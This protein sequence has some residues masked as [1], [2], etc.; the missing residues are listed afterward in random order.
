MWGPRQHY[1]VSPRPV[2]GIFQ[3]GKS[4][5][6]PQPFMSLSLSSSSCQS[7]PSS[8]PSVRASSSS[9]LH[10]PAFQLPPAP[11]LLKVFGSHSSMSLLFTGHP[12]HSPPLRPASGPNRCGQGGESCRTKHGPYKEDLGWRGAFL[13]FSY[14]ERLWAVSPFPLEGPFLSLGPRQVLISPLLSLPTE[15]LW[16]L[17]SK[18]P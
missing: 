7:Q 4:P 11:G 15:R 17:P 16:V 9:A 12:G 13:S 1:W 8:F 5:M 6:V 10:P 18:K 14:T 2:P 3:S